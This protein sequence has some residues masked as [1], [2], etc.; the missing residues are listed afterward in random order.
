[1]EIVAAVTATHEL[2]QMSFEDLTVATG[3]EDHVG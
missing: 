1:M 2:W 3:N